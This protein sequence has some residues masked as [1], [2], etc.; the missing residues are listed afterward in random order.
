MCTIMAPSSWKL[1]DPCVTNDSPVRFGAP[2]QVCVPDPRWV[3][4]EILADAPSR[5]LPCHG[6]HSFYSSL[7]HPPRQPAYLLDLFY[8]FSTFACPFLSIFLFPSHSLTKTSSVSVLICEILNRGLFC[9]QHNHLG[10]PATN[11]FLDAPATHINKIRARCSKTSS[12]GC[13]SR[14]LFSSSLA[15]SGPHQHISLVRHQRQFR[16]DL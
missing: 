10:S 7:P 11:I 8:L 16:T 9:S 5:I 2:V 4:A 13:P 1:L 15:S 3:Y 14:R 6:C 12:S